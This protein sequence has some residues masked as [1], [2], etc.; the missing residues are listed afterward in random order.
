MG[1]VSRDG[2]IVRVLGRDGEHRDRPVG[3]GFVVGERHL[4]TCAHVVN[5]ALGRDRNDPP[6]PATD[7]ILTVDFP[8]L[9]GVDGAPTR[10][11]RVKAWSPPPGPVHSDTGGWDVAGM[12]NVG[13]G[14]PAGAVAARL[15][16]DPGS[17][18]VV[19]M[20]GIPSL[21]RRSAGAW[22]QGTLLGRTGA[23]RLQLDPA[24]SSFFRAQQGYSG[25][26]VW[27]RASGTV[28]GMLSIAAAD[29]SGEAYAVPVTAL[30][31]VW[32]DVLADRTI[33]PNPYRGLSV[34]R[35]S[36]RNLFFG[37]E[38]DTERLITEVETKSLVVLFGAS[39]VGKSSL[40]RAGLIPRLDDRGDWLSVL[41]ELDQD[42]LDTLALE[43]AR[44]NGLPPGS[45]TGRLDAFIGQ[46]RDDGL[47]KTLRRLSRIASRSV[48]VVVDRFEQLL[49]EEVD[50]AERSE[51]LGLLEKAAAAGQDGDA[52]FTIVAAIRSDF[53]AALTQL[54][55]IDWLLR[56][57]LFSVSPMDSAA[58]RRVIQ[59]PARRHGVSYG[60][61]LAARIA[62]ETVGEGALPLLEFTLSQMWEH[63]HDRRLTEEEYEAIGGVEGALDRHAASVVAG[64]RGTPGDELLLRR[65]L[66]RLVTAAADSRPAVRRTA[67]RTEMPPEEWRTLT[68]LSGRR[69]RLVMIDNDRAEIAHEALITSWNLLAGWMREDAD[70]LDWRQR[71][72]DRGPNDLLT[73]AALWEAEQ[74]LQQRSEE[75]PE[76]V[77]SLMLRS[78]DAQQRRITELEEANARAAAALAQAEEARRRAEQDREN[79]ERNARR[80]DALRLAATADLLRVDGTAALATALAIAIESLRR[81]PTFAGD[82]AVR[83]ILASSPELVWSTEDTVAVNAIDIS[84]DG[85]LVV[86][87]DS[88]GKISIWNTI[89]GGPA[90]LS[91]IRPFRHVEFR[92][93]EPAFAVLF[94]PDAQ[95]LAT[96]SVR[97]R[98]QL[99][100]LDSPDGPQQLISDDSCV[101]APIFS[102]DGTF[103]ATI[104][105]DG[106]AL[107]WDLGVGLGLVQELIHITDDTVDKVA[108]S[109]GSLRI[110]TTNEKGQ[111]LVRLGMGAPF[112]VISH[113]E[114]IHAV[115]FT[116][117]GSRI[118][119]A[120][121]RVPLKMVGAADGREVFRVDHPEQLQDVVF[122]R[123]GGVCFSASLERSVSTRDTHSGKEI[124]RFRARSS[125]VAMSPDDDGSRVAI[126][127][128]DG[129]I[130]VHDVATGDETA[131]IDHSHQF[132]QIK[133]SADGTRLATISADRTA[134]M[135]KARAEAELLRFSHPDLVTAVCFSPDGSRLATACEDGPVRLWNIRTGEKVL[136]VGGA[137]ATNRV[138]FNLDGSWLVTGGDDGAATVW[139][140]A[141]GEIVRRVE[142]RSMVND[143]AISRDSRL[144]ATADAGGTVRVLDLTAPGNH[145]R[146]ATRPGGWI[147]SV[148]FDP[149]GRHVAVL[150]DD[151]ITAVWDCHTATEVWR[152]IDTTAA[153]FH[154]SGSVLATADVEGSVRLWDFLR[155]DLIDEVCR[156]RE[157]RS[158]TFSPDGCD[159]AVAGSGGLLQIWTVSLDAG[160]LRAESRSIGGGSW[161]KTS[162]FNATGS[163]IA[164]GG[165]DGTA[166]VWDVPSGAEVC[167][168]SHD[169]WV[170]AVAF[171]PN[172]M[173]LAS[174]SN[175]RTARLWPCDVDLLLEQAEN[176]LVRHLTPEE[177]RLY[178]I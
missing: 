52:R 47:A 130:R 43:L 159:L 96:V 25:S 129:P 114:P 154:P 38:A 104:R 80:A 101:K 77:R 138:R 32:P 107:I 178:R 24:A 95:R 142:H 175:D 109:P 169:D 139:E 29:G 128:R 4:L 85:S 86:V 103:M 87:G 14:M 141:S 54:P 49:Q 55:G 82:L 135:W 76:V 40:L 27:D 160:D 61:G 48:L 117:D 36:D 144:L 98:L 156:S 51:F 90:H 163:M 41:V 112:F 91:A 166:R 3:I 120:T 35:S 22:S 108:F 75:V 153:A 30:R 11:V 123:D 19:E 97:G 155:S 15:H 1:T 72:E 79:A 132:I 37:R 65:A 106:S 173:W 89:R 168:M 161:V 176:R 21:P 131:R 23:G 99:W 68:A 151:R 59:E 143:V 17:G 28:T 137:A 16:E 122:T 165:R 126:A 172:G 94:S 121:D 149:A 45:S 64:L 174:A 62:R 162:A 73:G 8:L 20:Y 26:P 111:A 152:G 92:H 150:T 13:E 69:A 74:Y 88:T 63:Q 118:V 56:D 146:F 102:P 113:D 18:A 167:R 53:I 171:S 10:R 148:E 83:R 125:P 147:T 5:S 145:Q 93:V 133:L 136:E 81:E 110:V 71:M 140:T 157:I 116:P 50:E 9:A 78:R 60:R 12:E 39:G 115:T 6:R 58:L 127:Y 44:T 164:T 170:S 124:I 34:F 66:L 105:A 31:E 67:L 42:P 134:Q 7:V 33:P 84:A 57:R 177:R 158:I 46:L 70:F 100:G 119:T 2:V